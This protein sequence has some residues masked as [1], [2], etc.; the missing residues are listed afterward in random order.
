MLSQMALWRLASVAVTSEEELQARRLGYWLRRVRE[1]RGESLKS[2]A[3]AAGL[4]ASSGSTV[5]MWEH[6]RREISV[7]QLRRLAR[8]YAVPVRL[9]TDPP[10]TDEER[11]DGAL[12]D[13]AAL[14]RG[15]WA[16]EA[17]P[18]RATDAELDAERRTLLQ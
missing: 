2:A 14:E 1:R 13:A 5:S 17:G 15:D 16:G 11:L 7:Q 18:G 10:M 9:F 4:A 3:I 12:A 8:F 6:G